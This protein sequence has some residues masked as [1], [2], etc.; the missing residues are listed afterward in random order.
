LK[1]YFW[2]R[3]IITR[4]VFDSFRRSIWKFNFKTSYFKMLYMS[5][6]SWCTSRRKWSK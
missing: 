1:T 4:L 6:F 2:F 3:W 5:Y